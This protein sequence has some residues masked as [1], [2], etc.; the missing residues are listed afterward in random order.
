M[1]KQIC[2]IVLFLAII[3]FSCGG[4]SQKEEK[5]TSDSKESENSASNEDDKSSNDDQSSDNEESSSSKPK[6]GTAMSYK[7]LQKYLPNSVKGYILNGDMKGQSIDMQGMS[8]SSAEADYKK[9][10][11]NLSIV[12][13]DYHAAASVY[14]SLTMA[15]SMNISIDNDQEKASTTTVKGIKGY[16][17]IDKQDNS[18]ELILG[19]NERFLLTIKATNQK[20]V[21]L[22]RSVAES[23]D[24]SELKGIK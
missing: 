20:N 17:R 5:A 6:A 23:M 16:Q 10:E 9:G 12:L 21:D 19:V 18:S 8:Y 13:V 7:E 4:G 3:C 2:F 24:L 11:D 14:Q 1:K 22:V 15:W